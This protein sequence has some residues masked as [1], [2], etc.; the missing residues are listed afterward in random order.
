MPDPR[1]AVLGGYGAVGATAVRR[2]GAYGYERL[3]IGGRNPARAQALC[4]GLNHAEAAHVDCEDPRS[5]KE[6]CADADVVVNCAGPSYRILDTVARAARAAGAHYVDAAGDVPAHRALIAHDGP[7]FAGRTAVFSAGLMPGL[8]GLLPRLIAE[9]GDWMDSYAGGA[10]RITPASAADILLAQGPDFGESLAAWSQG[11]VTSRALAPLRRV[12]LE[13]FPEP[14]DAMPFLTTESTRLAARLRLGEVRCYSVYVS[15][16]IPTALAM[17]WA[18]DPAL[19]RD[20]AAPLAEAAASDLHGRTPYYVLAFRTHAAPA[21]PRSLTLHT[22]DP[23]HL[24]GVVVALTTRTVLRGQ[25]GAGV[26]FAAEALEPRGIAD[27]LRGDPL[28]DSLT[29][30]TP[31]RDEKPHDRSLR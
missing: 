5:L 4:T 12:R 28:V 1:I 9:P 17:A 30:T 7:A 6:F 2:L 25:I 19:L 13:E 8:T 11:R 14:V 22:S 23:Y 3:R 20:H 16:A 24:S 29:L 27:A 10:V 18:D 31:H 15:E 21:P 26:H